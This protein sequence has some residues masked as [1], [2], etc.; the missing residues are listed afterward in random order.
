MTTCPPDHIAHVFP[1]DA[2]HLSQSW[3]EWVTS[4]FNRWPLAAI[5]ESR[6][7]AKSS[8]H[9]I[10]PVAGMRVMN[11]LTVRAHRSRFSGPSFREWGD[12]WS[13]GLES[14]L[15]SLR[16]NDVV[17][18]HLGGHPA[19]SLAQRAAATARVV[20]VYHGVGLGSSRAHSA[21]ADLLV[22]LRDDLADSLVRRGA[23]PDQVRILKPSIDTSVFVPTQTPFDE[24][25]PVLG[26][27]GRGTA[28]KDWTA[29]PEALAAAV[30][31]GFDASAELVGPASSVQIAAL[32]SVAS[33]LGV[34][35]RLDVVGPLP[36]TEVAARMRRWRLL[37][38]PSVGEGYGL[39]VLEA[40]S[41]R[42]PVIARRGALAAE[43]VSWSGVHVTERATF[44]TEV[45][46]V[47]LDQN[48]P[49][50]AS[51]VRN[52]TEAGAEW[53]SILDS[54]GCWRPRILPPRQS[55]RRALR[56]TPILRLRRGFST[57]ARG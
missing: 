55:L 45:V 8:V 12:D 25:S 26:F 52:H 38:L 50:P 44:G 18:I 54:I 9:V 22:V 24:A 36:A 7:A 40:A 17:V 19:A 34:G 10:A 27:V 4:Q 49:P 28:E 21:E 57:A 42:L 11:G 14:H 51:W 43:L 33:Q 2:R 46:R 48:R 30:A 39:V 32:M 13:R 31:E 53:D 56:L 15:G 16:P 3:D 29:V 6:L 35:D 37:L 20:V 47:L 41:S 1:Y 23:R 5:A